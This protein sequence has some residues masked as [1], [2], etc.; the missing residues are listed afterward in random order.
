MSPD[1]SLAGRRILSVDSTEAVGQFLSEVGT[2]RGA[3]LTCAASIAEALELFRPGAF[4]LVLL[5][6]VQVDG[7]GM[8]LLRELRRLDD[9][10]V[11]VVLTGQGGGRL[12]TEA[13][14]AGAD[15]YV[16]KQHLA[17]GGANEYL[18]DALAHA[19]E[20]RAG[21]IARRRLETMKTDF[22][23]MVTHDLRN[24]AGNVL[25]SLKL[26]RT[27]K[28]G[29]LTPQQQQLLDLAFRSAGK[30][31]GLI[32]D[33]LDFAKMDAGYLRLDRAE[34]DLMAVIRAS[35]DMARPQC[36]VKGLTLTV[37]GPERLLALIDA[38]KVE[39]V[40]D[41]LIS[42]AVKYTPDGGRVEV[43][44]EP[45]NGRATIEVHDSG[46][47][48]PADQLGSLFSKYHRVPGQATAGISGTGLGLMIIKE[49]VQA[50]GGTVAA[51]S[52]G[53]G[54]GT[55]FVVDL[56]LGTTAA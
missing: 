39:Q 31:V 50:H 23:S 9:D 45:G 19:F 38:A 15:A 26:L 24:P 14:R 13:M 33:Y 12:V 21:A 20:H 16:E 5:D 11:L 2:P 29:P 35:A 42:N 37:S 43:R 40:V 48:I 55:V 51:R 56:P 4:D 27:G 22:Y 34:C 1:R 3:E 44:V 36:E 41:N 30:F 18:F 46:V 54:Q 28:A 8:S 47:G 10:C 6:I 17:A 53:A 7:D 52:A 49:I 32:N 25:V